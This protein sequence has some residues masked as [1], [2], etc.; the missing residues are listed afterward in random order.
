[1]VRNS[2]VSVAFHILDEASYKQA[3]AQGVNL[4]GPQNTPV[5]NGVA[6][7]GPKPKLCYLLKSSSESSYGFSL[8]SV[9]GE[10]RRQVGESICPRLSQKLPISVIP[11]KPQTLVTVLLSNICNIIC[12]SARCVHG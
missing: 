5:T 7:P 3:K 12:R 6:K 11:R 10:L 9:K 4:C 1:M 8:R 2:G